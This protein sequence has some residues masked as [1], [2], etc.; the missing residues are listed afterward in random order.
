MVVKAFFHLSLCVAGTGAFGLLKYYF[1]T[2]HLLNIAAL[3]CLR[4]FNK[5]IQKLPNLLLNTNLYS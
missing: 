2:Q 4:N 5:Y 1:A 3:S